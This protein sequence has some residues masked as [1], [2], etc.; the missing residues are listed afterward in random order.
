MIIYL[1]R[2]SKPDVP[3]GTFYGQSDVDVT[4]PEYERTISVINQK[5]DKEK[6]KHIY[7]SPL[8][9][10]YH[11]AKTLNTNQAGFHTDK[12]ILELNFGRWE[13]RKW[14][15]IDSKELGKW[16]NDFVHAP[17]P[18]GES[19]MDLYKR[20]SEFW[21]ELIRHTE[22]PLAVV[23]HGGVIKSILSRILESPLNKSYS[24][25]VHYGELISV[26]YFGEDQ[27]EIEFLTSPE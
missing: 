27:Y 24:I 1:I 10:C 6:L 15:K 16:I 23:T 8:K 17:T 7:T 9:R 21:D 19:H 4:R 18:D 20:V 2:H 12:R 26:Q 13:L 25:K 11:L 22:G 3:Q 5:V 14:D